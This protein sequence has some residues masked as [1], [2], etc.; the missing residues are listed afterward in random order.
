MAEIHKNMGFKPKI[1]CR[2]T[3]EGLTLITSWAREGL[4]N[5]QIANNMSNT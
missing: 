4:S 3:D 2:L 1:D 5:T